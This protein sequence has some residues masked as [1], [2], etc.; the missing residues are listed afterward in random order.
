M[1]NLPERYAYAVTQCLPQA[2]RDDV[3]KELLATI[4][5]MAADRA[6][7]GEPIEADYRAVLK[8]LG[9]PETLARKYTAT[10][11]YLIGPKWFDAYWKLLVTLISIVPVIVAAVVSVVE[12]AQGNQSI[13]QSLLKGIGTGFG[14]I[15][16]IGF[17]TTVVFAVLERTT[18]PQDMTAEW[19]PEDLPEV[20]KYPNRQISIIESG[21]AAGFVA[22]AAIWLAVH[23]FI[24]AKNGETLFSATIGMEWVIAIFAI[25]GL[26]FLHDLW[27]LKVGNWT[28]PITVTSILLATATVIYLVALVSTQQVINPEYLRA[29]GVSI[30]Q[31]QLDNAIRL[32][33]GI[34]VAAIV[35]S[36]IAESIQAV[37][38]NRRLKAKTTK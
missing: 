37:V 30:P 6:K 18:K 14:A 2:Q 23:P 4:E 25:I 35:I 16:H 19:K 17:W 38:M 20:P 21:F 33:V 32:S 11:R 31:D 13:I 12:I 24:N 27:K 26:A 8:E 10:R 3:A 7:T 36:E 34:T 29:W 5:D 1:T 22:L 9:N 15:V 28:T